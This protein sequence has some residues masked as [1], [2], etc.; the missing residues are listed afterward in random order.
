[1]LRFDQYRRAEL[2]KFDRILNLAHSML[3]SIVTLFCHSPHKFVWEWKWWS[4]MHVG[5]AHKKKDEQRAGSPG[6]SP[7]CSRGRAG[8]HERSASFQPIRAHGRRPLSGWP[9]C[10][11]LCPAFVNLHHYWFLKNHKLVDLRIQLRMDSTWFYR[12]KDR[13]V[14]PA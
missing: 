13:I 8:H 1:M 10:C 12:S 4:F 11:Q 5:P 7:V 14:S 3:Q 6:R 2:G 9:P